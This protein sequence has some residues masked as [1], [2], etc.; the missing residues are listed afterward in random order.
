MKNSGILVNGSLVLLLLLLLA[1]CQA[2]FTYSPLSFLQRDPANLPLD[3]KIAWAE[4]ALASGDLEAM[5]TAYDAIKDESGVDY[6]AANLALELSG[7][8]QLLFEVIEGNIDYSAITDMNDFLAD[9]VDSEYVSYAAGDFWATL[10]NDPDSLTGTDYI[11]G[12]ACILFDAGGGDLATLALVDVTGP[13]T[14]DGFIQQGI[15][16]LPTDDP[17]VEYLNDLSGFL[18]DGLF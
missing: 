6:L 11:L 18:T 16:N 14:A 17:A 2:I 8:P 13:G 9:N 12:A 15:L 3:Q 5:A 1:G 4:N 10:S 7:V